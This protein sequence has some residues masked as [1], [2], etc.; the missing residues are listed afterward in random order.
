VYTL[1]VLGVKE[2]GWKGPEQYPLILS[3]VIKVAQFI[4]VQQALKLSKPLDNTFDDNSAYK[5][6][7][8]R[9]LHRQP[10]GCLQLVQEIIDK[11]IVQGSYSL[12]QW[13]LD[14]QT[15]RLKIYYNTTSRG[16]VE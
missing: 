8:S 16:H 9:Q 13:M 12:M 14:L 2:N 5:S 3:A 1:A 6:N 7:S 11:F 4:V 15:Y 10:K